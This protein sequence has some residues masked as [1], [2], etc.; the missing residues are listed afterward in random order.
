MNIYEGRTLL[1]DTQV[2]GTGFGTWFGNN[3][4]RL[5]SRNYLF[6]K[7]KVNVFDP[8]VNGGDGSVPM[9]ARH[10]T[11]NFSFVSPK[12]LTGISSGTPSEKALTFLRYPESPSRDRGLTILIIL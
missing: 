10:Q 9:E 2:L 7:V 6:K 11:E 12:G 1:I 4:R 3:V 8:P 5:V